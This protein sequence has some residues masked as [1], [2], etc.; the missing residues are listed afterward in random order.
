MPAR[1]VARSSTTGWRVE[2]GA[3]WMDS[4]WRP[5]NNVNATGLPEP[6]VLIGDKR[7]FMAPNFY[8][9]SQTGL[10]RLQR[11]YIR[12][13][14]DAFADTTNVVQLT[15][16]EYSGPLEFVQFWID[17]I[18]EWEDEHKKSVLVGLSAPKDV[19]DAILADEKRAQREPAIGGDEGEGRMS[20][21]IDQARQVGDEGTQ[22]RAHEQSGPEVVD[23]ARIQAGPGCAVVHP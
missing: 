1:P 4:P 7:I 22:N 11:S 6:P 12:Q 20:S 17:V 8:D 23:L 21:V 10:R 5:A 16:A 2:A 3:H 18:G 15:S 14:L 9:P 13:C 19:Q